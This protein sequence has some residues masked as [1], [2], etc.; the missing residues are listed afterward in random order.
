MHKLQRTRIRDVAAGAAALFGV[1]RLVGFAY[2]LL[3]PELQN[4]LF[5]GVS[6]VVALCPR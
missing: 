4:S 5:L 2:A 6:V 3:R 1:Q